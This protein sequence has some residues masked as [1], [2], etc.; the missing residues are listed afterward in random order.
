SPGSIG[1][2]DFLMHSANG[3][4]GA[5]RLNGSGAGNDFAA[6]QRAGR[7]FIDD[8]EGEDQT[9]AG[10]ANILQQ[11]LH[12]DGEIVVVF[13]QHHHGG[14]AVVHFRFKSDINLCTV[15]QHS[16]IERFLSAVLDQHSGDL[17]KGVHLNAVQ[18]QKEVAGLQ[19]ALCG[20]PIH[21]AVHGK[22]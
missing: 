14:D 18:T 9:G 16:N 17:I 3:A 11:N 13:K 5:V 19:S 8:A 1:G 2:I 15:T 12:I 7:E 10:S 6:G 22:A 20:R 4:H 21:Q